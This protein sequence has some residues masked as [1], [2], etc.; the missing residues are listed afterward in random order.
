MSGTRAQIEEED[1][2]VRGLDAEE[3]AVYLIRWFRRRY[4]AP[5]SHRALL[6]LGTDWLDD[7]HQPE[8]FATSEE[9]PEDALTILTERFEGVASED[10]VD[11]VASRL[12]EESPHWFPVPLTE[13]AE[14]TADLESSD[15]DDEA[16]EPDQDDEIDDAIPNDATE[17]ERAI[18]RR[19]LEVYRQRSLS[20]DTEIHDALRIPARAAA[21]VDRRAAAALRALKERTDKGEISAPST[22]PGIGHNG[23]PAD[24][25]ESAFDEDG[26]E[27]ALQDMQ[28]EAE[29]PKPKVDV[30]RRS[31]WRA[32]VGLACVA[33]E[34][35]REMSKGGLEFTGAQIVEELWKHPDELF[36]KLHGVVMAAE[37]FVGHIAHHL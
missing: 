26:L 16:S 28:A 33:L 34:V 15:S 1:H 21:L 2:E 5:G 27:R 14:E 8:E 19:L 11:S 37:V 32:L 3:Q 29:S 10:V 18:V 24:K 22:S 31:R 13:Y 6:Q 30:V 25:I 12:E 20:A 4:T 35:V 9:E 36:H 7:D 17:A 23:P